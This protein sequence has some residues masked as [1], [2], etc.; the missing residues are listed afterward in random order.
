MNL[1]RRTFVTASA[2]ALASSAIP[3][4]GR[5]AESGFSL[6]QA[7]ALRDDLDFLVTTMIDVGVNPFVYTSR[8]AF[9]AR[10]ATI[11]AGLTEPLNVFGYYLRIA[12]LFASL[13]DGHLSLSIGDAFKTYRDGGGEAFPLQVDLRETGVYASETDDPAVPAGSRILAIDGVAMEAIEAAALTMVSGQT[14]ALRRYFA[15]PNIVRSYLFY[16]YGV[17]D[18]YA[19]RILR[20]DGTERTVRVAAT[21]RAHLQELAPASSSDAAQSA[22]YTFARMADGR[23]GYINYL[24]CHDLDAFKTF[25]RTTFADIAN[26]PID[27][28]VIDIRQN[29]GGA[30]DLNDVL[31]SYVTD[32]PFAQFGGS[33]KKVSDL[34]K[35][36]YGKAKYVEIYGDAA[37]RAKDGAILTNR[38]GGPAGHETYPNRYGGPV[39]LLIGIGTFSS[40]MS[41]ATAAKDFGLATIV[42]EETAEPVDSNGEVF[43]GVAPQTK[44]AFGFPTK[45]FFG[46]K[47]RP[48]GQ[49]V[50]PD[51]AIHTSDADIAAKRDPVL[52]YAIGKILK[53]S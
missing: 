21:T 50:V 36:T 16:R 53:R 47:P 45:Y 28:L 31:W 33:S 27:G 25:L 4:A 18:D 42:G 40:A 30:S 15:G 8:A 5:A 41:C 34:L 12:P 46:P 10:R 35:R 43:S 52:D 17:R 19:L 37:W 38:E 7:S 3:H 20:P 26:K 49:G 14:L 23:V 6:F 32:K 22:D 11:E 9:D 1:T 39:Y 13:N 24:S 51:V 44:L 2:A 29:G 48:A